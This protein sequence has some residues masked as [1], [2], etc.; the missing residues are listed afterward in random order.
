[1]P[2]ASSPSPDR[3]LVF[4]GAGNMAAALVRGLLAQGV[5]PDRIACL[6]GSGASARA[7]SE[8]TGIVA[9]PADAPGTAP[10]WVIACKPHQLGDLN[11]AVIAATRDRLVISVLAGIPLERLRTVFPRAA[12]LVRAMP[13]T[14]AAIGKGMTGWAADQPLEPAQRQAVDQL[15]AATGAA[16]E[17]D[18]RALDAVTAVSGS[19]PAYV[20]EIARV[21][22]EA[23]V[24]QGLTPDQARLLVL[25]TLEGATALMLEDSDP[26]PGS[27][28][29]QVTSKGGTTAPALAAFE[30]GNLDSLFEEALAAAVRR[31]REIAG[32]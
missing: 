1:M 9:L 18:E 24:K 14:P 8:K 21:W 19:G 30:A 4:V 7:L 32:N 31:A 11:P 20:F 23:G 29:N 6:S 26:D 5:P 12:R 10:V 15:M 22:I 2:P 16:L 28:R 25:K 27:L 13:N 3:D 17:V